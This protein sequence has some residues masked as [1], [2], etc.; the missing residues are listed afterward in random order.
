MKKQSVSQKA[1]ERIVKPIFTKAEEIDRFSE[2]IASHSNSG[3]VKELLERPQLE[4]L[5][6]EFSEKFPAKRGFS[7][8][9]DDHGKRLVSMDLLDGVGQVNYLR[10]WDFGW[11]AYGRDCTFYREYAR[12]DDCSELVIDKKHFFLNDFASIQSAILLNQELNGEPVEKIGYDFLVLNGYAR[13]DI[14]LKLLL[15][16]VIASY[17]NSKNDGGD[18]TGRMTDPVPAYDSGQHSENYYLG[19]AIMGTN[20]QEVQKKECEKWQNGFNAMKRQRKKFNIIRI[21]P[22]RESSGYITFAIDGSF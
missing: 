13:E 6:N 10:N 15:N 17:I 9:G 4:S 16:G 12:P 22:K 21:E 7:F 14:S 1:F 11:R 19:L 3:V 20:S 18:L 2:R 5:V 8:Y